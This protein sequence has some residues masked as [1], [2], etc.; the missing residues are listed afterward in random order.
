MVKG[1]VNDV[2]SRMLTRVIRDVTQVIVDQLNNLVQ[3]LK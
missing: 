3:K 2:A 1:V